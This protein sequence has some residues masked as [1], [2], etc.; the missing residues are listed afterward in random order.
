M[1]RRER[2]LNDDLYYCD[3]R[4]RYRCT[5]RKLITRTITKESGYLV[6]QFNLDELGLL[7]TM[8]EV[9]LEN[10]LESDAPQ[11]II[12]VLR[13]VLSKLQPLIEEECNIF[14]EFQE[15]TTQLDDLHLA[16]KIIVKNPDAVTTDY[17]TN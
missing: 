14:N 15:L 1:D 9:S 8:I 17:Q 2:L 7:H 3:H 10:G 11:Q 5:D 16:S 12:D 13:S 6:S 4:W